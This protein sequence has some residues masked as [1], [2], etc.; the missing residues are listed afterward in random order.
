M[1][2]PY[3]LNNADIQ[4]VQSAGQGFVAYL[5]FLNPVSVTTNWV[6]TAL[7]QYG[8]PLPPPNFD[9]AA[10]HVAP[11][12][13]ICN[14]GPNRIGFVGEP[15]YFDGSRSCQRFDMPV[16]SYQWSYTGGLRQSLC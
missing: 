11:Y 6:D 1:A 2:S 16:V 8:N 4:F 9:T 13:P 15:L 14:I 7:D 10:N 3:L 5:A 12:A